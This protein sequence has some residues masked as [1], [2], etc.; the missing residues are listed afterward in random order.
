MEDG[1][2]LD[3]IYFSSFTILVNF[4]YQLGAGMSKPV[5]KSVALSR[6]GSMMIVIF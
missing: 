3:F 6:N 5:L 1:R 4:P 2:F